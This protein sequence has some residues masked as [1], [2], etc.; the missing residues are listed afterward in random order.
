MSIAIFGCGGFGK[1]VMATVRRLGHHDAFFVS[2]AGGDPVI[3]AAHVTPDALEP[4][5]RLIVAVG[6]GAARRR[7][8][9][10]FSHLEAMT[11]IAATCLIAPQARIGAG[12]V[13]CDLVTVSPDAVIGARNQINL[14]CF[15]AHDVVLGDDVTLA[16]NVVMGGNSQVGD[17]VTI[18]MGALIRNGVAGRPLTIGA[19]ATIGM[20]A[21]VTRDVPPGATV[22][23]NPAR[24]IQR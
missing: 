11:L 17:G 3:G 7:L 24:P 4:H 2:D 8:Y 5:H 14:R 6:D 23:G 18:G 12:S 19:G 22:V 10:R 21:V 1:E 13:L 9:D 20:G 16:P 15:V